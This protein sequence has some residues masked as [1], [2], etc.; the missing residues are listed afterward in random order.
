MNRAGRLLKWQVRSSAIQTISRILYVSHAKKKETEQF[1]S[2]NFPAKGFCVDSLMASLFSA[3][4]L[5][6][7]FDFT[8]DPYTYADIYIGSSSS[9]A[10]RGMACTLFERREIP[11]EDISRDRRHTMIPLPF[12]QVSIGRAVASNGVRLVWPECARDFVALP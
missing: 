3:K 9:F 8:G 11:I 4:R 2:Q 10:L 12:R 7:K 6:S 5:I 1:Y